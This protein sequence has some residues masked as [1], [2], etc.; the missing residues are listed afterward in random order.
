VVVGHV[1]Q[2]PDVDGARTAATTRARHQHRHEREGG[3]P[4]GHGTGR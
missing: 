4:S 2:E 1:L 3:E